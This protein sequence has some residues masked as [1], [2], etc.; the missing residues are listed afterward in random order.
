MTRITEGVYALR[1]AYRTDSER[2]EHFYGHDADCHGNYPIDYFVWAICR[3]DDVVLVDAGFTVETAKRRGARVYLHSP[4]E[5][6][7][8]LGREPDEVSHVIL[9][10]LHYDHTGTIGQFPNAMAHLQRR[11]HDFWQSPMALRGSYPHLVEPGDLA[12]IAE[13]AADG[14]L[15]LE[16]GD[17]SLDEQISV[18][19]VGGHTPGLQVVRVATAHH[20]V[21]LAADASHFYE[22][23][24]N[25]RPYGIVHELPRMYE[26]FDRLH[27][28][29]GVGGTI[30][31]G[32]DPRVRERHDA[33]PGLDGLVY[34]LVASVSQP[35][36]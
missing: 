12:E 32:H 16:E 13:R 10:H 24:E 18:H 8:M 14:R 26:A 6:L 22:N 7:N 25:D 1:F 33:L 19:L 31:P 3:D 34:S 2:G 11:E 36:T 30:V 4:A 27:E 28:L 15:S 35:A 29:A 21:V 23:L 17:W 5:L 9:S 20:P